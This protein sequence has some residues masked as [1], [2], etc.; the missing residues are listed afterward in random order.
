MK[1]VINA[2]Y[3]TVLVLT[4][5][6]QSLLAIAIV[7]FSWLV[8]SRITEERHIIRVRDVVFFSISFCLVIWLLSSDIFTI[9]E[10]TKQYAR[11]TG[12]SRSTTISDSTRTGLYEYG[13][14]LFLSNPI[15]GWGYRNIMHYTHSTYM[16]VL[17]GTGLMGFLLFYIPIIRLFS[18]TIANMRKSEEY[19]IKMYYCKR[20]VIFIV[21]FTIMLF[22]ATHYYNIAILIMSML[23]CDYYKRTKAV[24][25]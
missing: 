14:Q 5:S 22:R 15:L 16:E 4:A 1:L 7:Y 8:C 13:F 24:V 23:Y 2:L 6:R 20:I 3:I 18:S 17:A 25:N 21:I 19:N 12:T 11:L 9:F 10:R